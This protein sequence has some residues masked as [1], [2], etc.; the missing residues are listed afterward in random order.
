M[1]VFDIDDLKQRSIELVRFVDEAADTYGFDR[2]RVVAT[3]YSNGANI[4]ASILLMRPDAFAGAALFHAMKPFDPEVTP[5]LA[6]KPLFL[7]GGQR[8]PMIPAA[9]TS[10]L[11]KML[12]SAG[13]DVT[14]HW[15]P[16]GHELTQPEIEAAREWFTS[17]F[18][19]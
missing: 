5:D 10:A 7:S 18:V 1:G 3:G 15:A 19:S 4:A 8:D 13:A 6:G 2:G 14:M 17:T 11:E 9:E 12:A 16:G